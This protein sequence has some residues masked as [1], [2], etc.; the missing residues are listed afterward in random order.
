ML[1]HVVVVAVGGENGASED[2]FTR[3]DRGRSGVA[4]EVP[5]Q[6]L[7]PLD[8][9]RV[10]VDLT[11]AVVVLVVAELG[12]LGAHRQVVVVTVD[13]AVVAIATRI[14]HGAVSVVIEVSKCRFV[15]V[16]VDVVLIADFFVAGVAI[17][18]VVITVVAQGLVV[19]AQ[20]ARITMPV[21]VLVRGQIR[22]FPGLIVAAVVGAVD[23]VVAIGWGVRDAAGFVGVGMLGIAIFRAVAERAV[24]TV[25]IA[26]AKVTG[27]LFVAFV[28]TT[29]LRTGAAVVTPTGVQE[30][31]KRGEGEPFVDAH[32]VGLQRRKG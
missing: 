15:A 16:F 27:Y 10:V 12:L 7:V 3:K 26:G 22:A 17:R 18:V 8:F 25:G 5:V 29:F 14:G 21:A 28:S 19:L 31:E 11:V 9:L 32:V 1:R 23:S 30:S 2:N 20:A 6:V 4:K 24:V 13:S